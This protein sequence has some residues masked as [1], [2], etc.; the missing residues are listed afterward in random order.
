MCL[1]LK[2]AAAQDFLYDMPL[3]W[4]SQTTIPMYL[5]NR[6][7]LLTVKSGSSTS[8]V[9]CQQY[10]IQLVD[11]IPAWAVFIKTMASPHT[12][13]QAQVVCEYLEGSYCG[14]TN[15]LL[16]HLIHADPKVFTVSS[17][18]HLN[19]SYKS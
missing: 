12:N 3:V 6:R 15:H 8:A 2:A 16:H 17:L 7:C 18:S 9:V 5:I 14:S 10:E 11:G 1:H 13:K 19:I 4:Q